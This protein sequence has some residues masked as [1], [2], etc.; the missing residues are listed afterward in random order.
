MVC[1]KNE[2]MVTMPTL[3]APKI[4]I[5]KWKH[6][7]K[8]NITI[9]KALFTIHKAEVE[10][11]KFHRKLST[12]AHKNDKYMLMVDCTIKLTMSE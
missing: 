6:E 8:K 2:I 12:R 10:T 4:I 11:E 9:T 1:H 5:C 7:L 3:V